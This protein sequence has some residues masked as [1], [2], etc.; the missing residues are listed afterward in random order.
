ME[1]YFAT[2]GS[3]AAFYRQHYPRLIRWFAGRLR[4]P[5]QALELTAET[6]AAA[7]AARLGFKGST[8]RQALAWIFAIAYSKLE[9]FRRDASVQTRA[10]ERLAF[11]WPPP[12]EEELRRVE[13]M[14]D[15][16]A[17][18]DALDD[19]MS[20]LTDAEREVV[21]RHILDGLGFA[22]IVGPAG[23]ETPDAARMRLSRA[24]QK[25]AAHRALRE[26]YGGEGRA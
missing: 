14:A 3:F 21:E 2:P 24:R 20:K 13:E 18:G 19:A 15:A 5:D 23:D 22:E 10:L 1:G 6:F 17:A 9:Q 11:A 7:Y 12:D 26:H 4:G 25:L 8:D 16:E